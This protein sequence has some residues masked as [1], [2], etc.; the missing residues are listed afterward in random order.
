MWISLLHFQTGNSK[1]LS[2]RMLLTCRLYI[3]AITTVQWLRVRLLIGRCFHVNVVEGFA[4]RRSLAAWDVTPLRHS[5]PNETSVIC[6]HAACAQLFIHLF[7]F[8]TRTYDSFRIIVALA[9]HPSKQ[10]IL[11]HITFR[12][13]LHI[14]IGQHL[15][16]DHEL[17]N[18]PSEK[19]AYLMPLFTKRHVIHSADRNP[20]TRTTNPTSNFF[21][22]FL[23]QFA[24]DIYLV[25]PAKNAS[26]CLD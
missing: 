12:V 7:I 26:S 5:S 10:Q 20:V 23:H 21:L 2:H 15:Y 11:H 16:V 1:L 13:A 9:L 17:C 14:N 18:G 24:D 3:Q 6:V 25:V 22:N 19:I 4:R 8:Y